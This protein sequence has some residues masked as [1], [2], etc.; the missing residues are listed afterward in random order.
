MNMM[1]GSSSNGASAPTSNTG[2]GA[3]NSFPMAEVDTSMLKDELSKYSYAASG[4]NGGREKD[5]TQ[6]FTAAF[7][8]EL[9]RVVKAVNQY[10]VELEYSSKSL[11]TSVET[12]T[13]Q[14][15]KNGRGRSG[16]SDG[17]AKLHEMSQKVD[18]FVQSCITLQDTSTKSRYAMLEV[19]QKADGQINHQSTTPTSTFT[20]LVKSSFPARLNSVLVVVASD[21]YAQIRTAEKTL[22]SDGNEEDGVWKAPSSF[23]RTTTKYWVKEEQLTNLML[24]CAGEAPLLV[25]GKKGT[26]T[27]K[28]NRL[29]PMSEGDKLWSSMVTPITSVYFD[30]P[31]MS[32]YKKR[33]ARIEG[34]QLLRVRWYGTTMP[35]GDGIIFLELKTHHEKW[36]ANKSVKERAAVQERDM[37]KFLTPIPWTLEQA[38]EIIIRA[39]PTISSDELTKSTNLLARMHKLVVKHTLRSCVRSVYMRAAFQSAKSNDLRLTLDRNVTLVDETSRNDPTG[40]SWCLSDDDAKNKAKAVVVPF[41]VFEVK[42][43]GENPMP[44]GLAA[45]IASG[46]I[47]EAPKFSKFLSGAAAFNQHVMKKLPYWAGN[48][49]FAQMFGMPASTNEN[50]QD[51]TSGM[52]PCDCYQLFGDAMSFNQSSGPVK[53]SPLQRLLKPESDRSVDGITKTKNLDIAPKTPVRVEPKSYFANERTFIQW[54]SASLLLLTVATIMMSNAQFKRTSAM[55]AFS[56]FFLVGYATF[57]YFRRIKL[58]SNGKGYG[59]IDKLGPSILALGVGFGIFAVFFDI[60]SETDMLGEKQSQNKQSE[61]SNW[62]SS[63]YDKDDDDDRRLGTSHL[64]RLVSAPDL[65][66]A[67]FEVPGACF[68]QSL[69]GINPLTFEPNDATVDMAKNSLLIAST[70]EIL[71][72]PLNGG[73]L[74]HLAYLDNTELGGITIFGDR[75][76]ALSGGPVHSELLEFSWVESGSSLEQKGSWT[77]FESVSEI[78]GLDIIRDG[79]EAKFYIGTNGSVH[80]YRIPGPGDDALSRVDN[81][82][83]K[84]INQGLV[85]NDTIASFH[86]FEGITYF[87]H[88]ASNVLRAWDLSTGEFLAEIPLPRVDGVLS[89]EWKGFTLERR[90]ANEEEDSSLRGMTKSSNVYLH[91]AGD[92]PPQIWTFAMEET[93]ERGQIAFPTCASITA[94]SQK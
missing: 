85:P 9:A 58:L 39:S 16:G 2:P 68:R 5:Y 31:D 38:R 54:I 60:V 48:P 45:L 11:L 74:S 3:V 88:S 13:E 12:S 67:L 42:L 4:S 61:R 51:Y 1:M 40:K 92:A 53:R 44:Q 57:V 24:T 8:R 73:E 35:K 84:M 14:I 86:T 50:A 90:N 29:M 28:M 34:A 30:S 82:N 87:M 62:F 71:A 49:A 91:L 69:S 43:V 93:G 41:E 27:P 83:M 63:G 20:D 33:L 15:K 47:E 75:I 25:Y 94:S 22:T 79:E 21:I 80:S 81:L 56:A 23:Q 59:Y 89:G 46:V 70:A 10:Q 78:N 36:V 65:P 77:I 17:H 64:R 7:Q 19:A 76:F 6:P 72:H 18:D 66:N 55:I 32:M 37:V 26:L 52:D